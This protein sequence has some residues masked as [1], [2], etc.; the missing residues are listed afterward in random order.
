MKTI[1]ARPSLFTASVRNSAKEAQQRNE[2][3]A[4]LINMIYQ[5][6]LRRKLTLRAI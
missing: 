1:P 6:E 3:R 4:Q 2:L 5:N